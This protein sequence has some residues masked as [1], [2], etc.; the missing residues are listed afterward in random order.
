MSATGLAPYHL[1]IFRGLYFRI[2]VDWI[3]AISEAVGILAGTCAGKDE[4]PDTFW[5]IEGCY[6]STTLLIESQ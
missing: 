4:L 3:R 6:L 1:D 5:V 2:S